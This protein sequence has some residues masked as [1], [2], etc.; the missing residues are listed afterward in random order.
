MI[1]IVTRGVLHAEIFDNK[2]ELNT[3]S[4]VLPQ[5]WNG[6]ALVVASCIEA[7]FKEFVVEAVGLRQAVHAVG[8][9]TKCI[10]THQVWISH[11]RYIPVFISSV[12][13]LSFILA[14][15]GPLSGVMR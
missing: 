9:C 14:Y 12:I 6:G 13:S 15:Y 1:G 5:T 4:V 10:P 3:L 7:L 11:G 8:G 2:G